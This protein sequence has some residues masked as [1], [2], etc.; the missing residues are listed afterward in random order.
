[1]FVLPALVLCALLLTGCAG[2]GAPPD[3]I[4]PGVF[5]VVTAV[6][7]RCKLGDDP[8]LHESTGDIVTEFGNQVK[9]FIRWRAEEYLGKPGGD[10]DK[11][12]Q[13]VAKEYET[14]R[15]YVV[16][17]IGPDL[18][19]PSGLIKGTDKSPPHLD[20]NDVLRPLKSSPDPVKEVT[21]LI[22]EE[23]RW[24]RAN[25]IIWRAAALEPQIWV[26]K[27][28]EPAF[29][30]KA[31]DE[32]LDRRLRIVERL[33]YQID[34]ETT[35]GTLVPVESK[36]HGEW[37]DGA[38]VRMFEYPELKG[39]KRLR[40]AIGE[41]N[42]GPGKVWREVP[43]SDLLI[44]GESTV[45]AGTRIRDDAAAAFSAP[46]PSWGTDYG[47]A[48]EPTSGA[49]VIDDLFH[50]SE[51]WWD[52]SWIY[53][54]EVLAA[55]HLDALRFGKVRRHNDNDATFNAALASHPKGW[56]GLRPAVGLFGP[57]LPL[58]A[59]DDAKPLSEP[60]L[61]SN[62]PV[63]R[64][65]L[66]DHVV[67]M[68]SIMYGLLS[69]GAWS[70]ENAVVV[71]L[72]SD[73][74]SNDFGDQLKLMGHGTTA[75][76]EAEFKRE[77]AEELDAMI[78]FGRVEAK[79]APPGTDT[80]PWVRQGAP[81][82]RW[83]PYG[84]PWVDQSL[85]PQSPWWIRIPYES[86]GDWVGRALGRNATLETLPDAIE[87]DYSLPS[88]TGY[89]LPPGAASGP[90]KECYFPLW[91][92]AQEG[93]WKGYLAQRKANQPASTF[94]LKETT[95]VARNIP[96]LAAPWEFVPGRKPQHVFT[97]RPYVTR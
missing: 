52:R 39:T 21:K 10:T 40:K 36:P 95:F 4:A 64:L 20:L 50:P 45:R 93:R 28:E 32:L 92:A 82:V 22:E 67:C 23:K 24:K 25:S 18:S 63:P 13:A 8:L 27:P 59:D 66:G 69:N 96:G 94:K 1:M 53:C 38:R 62:G 84:E 48:I 72:N 68:N 5:L 2:A 41:A 55:L 6:W 76:T 75:L 26:P 34:T 49:E 44:Y 57:E 61:F 77:R 60:R 33:W 47:Y 42:I 7:K 54:D 46:P 80:I 29:S 74:K 81:L 78:D 3:G 65:Q 51:D 85:Q 17:T 71:D 15:A 90:N 35:G 56:A 87:V 88:S 9:F 43:H 91:V 86:T 58:F 83:A 37:Y 97:V 79:A 12:T 19:H 73:W 16:K 70:L 30:E 11:A 14:I 31:M 89:R